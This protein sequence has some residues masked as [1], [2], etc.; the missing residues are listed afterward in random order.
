MILR[1]DIG[2][3]EHL[4]NISCYNNNYYKLPL[5]IDECNIVYEKCNEDYN[6][7]MY[8]LGN[9]EEGKFG[10]D[11]AKEYYSADNHNDECLGVLVFDSKLKH[12]WYT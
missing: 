7:Y 2:N 11:N 8:L 1:I 3:C 9:E 5:D 6:S 10:I 12:V 4:K